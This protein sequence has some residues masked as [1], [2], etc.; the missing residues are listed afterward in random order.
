MKASR[1][2]TASTTTGMIAAV[3]TW[4]FEEFTRYTIPADVAIAVA[5]LLS[6]M[7]GWCTKEA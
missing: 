4:I 6:M 7:V 2:L 5:T 1:K 3:L